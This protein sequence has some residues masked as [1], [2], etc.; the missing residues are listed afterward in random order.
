VRLLLAGVLA[1]AALLSAAPASAA[2][3]EPVSLKGS[4]SNLPA[5]PFNPPCNIT[6]EQSCSTNGTPPGQLKVCPET[7]GWTSEFGP[8]CPS[9]WIGPYLPG[10]PSNGGTDDR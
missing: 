2:L 1:A 3:G 8:Q 10:N 4:I 6:P 5:D 7:G 9:L